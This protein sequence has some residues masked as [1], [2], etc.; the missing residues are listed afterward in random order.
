M[1]KIITRTHHYCDGQSDCLSQLHLS[2]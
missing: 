1:L 2:L